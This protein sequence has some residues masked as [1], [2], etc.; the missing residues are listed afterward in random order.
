[1][2]LAGAQTTQMIIYLP[3]SLSR[4]LVFVLSSK[5]LEGLAFIFE[6]EK[7]KKNKEGKKGKDTFFNTLKTCKK[8]KKKAF[9][10]EKEKKKKAGG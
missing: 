6:L 4:P 9:S 2:F 8:S 10:K 7:R 3:P 1:M 5:H